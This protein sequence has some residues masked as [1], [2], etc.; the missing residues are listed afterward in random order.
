M[1]KRNIQLPQG[2]PSL[3]TYYFY[4]T[5]GCNLACQH[6]WIAP[7]Y[8]ANGGTGGHLDYDLFVLAIE[9]GL[10]LGLRNVKLTGGEP[11]LHPDFLRMVDFLRENEL[12]LTIESNGILLTKSIASYLKDKSTLRHISISLDGAYAETHDSFRGVRGSYK[13]TVQAIQS[14]VEV[15]IHPQ[16]IMSI[17]NGNVSEIEALVRLAEKLGAQTVKFNLITTAGR[18]EIMSKRGHTLN[19]E[20]LIDTGKWVENDLQRDVSIPL[21][22]SWPI[23]FESLLNLSRN[24][25]KTCDIAGI[26]GILPDG[27]VAMCGIGT[28]IPELCYGQ[29][30]KDKV[31]N[32]WFNNPI[33]N[34]LRQ[35]FSQ[36]LEGVC[37]ECLFRDICFG[38]CVADNY[39]FSGRLTAAV[40]VLCSGGRSTPFSGYKKARQ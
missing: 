17:H 28:T 25:L 14:L 2:I 20:H 26:L 6:C 3:N 24:N 5:A 27:H 21:Y 39:S 12:S 9:E 35:N 7:N 32:I 38:N 30:G 10:P 22:Y 33:V 8:Q 1:V 11:L 34:E 40:L 4:L 19:I 16:V 36:K 15:D 13:K 29:L 37:S 31:E 23:A 18:G